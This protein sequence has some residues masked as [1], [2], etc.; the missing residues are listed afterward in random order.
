M[1]W[2]VGRYPWRAVIH[3]YLNH[4]ASST[5]R[6]GGYRRSPAAVRCETAIL[7]NRRSLVCFGTDKKL[8]SVK[9]DRY[10]E[11]ALNS[12]LLL[13]KRK[14]HEASWACYA[15]RPGMPEGPLPVIAQSHLER[16]W[17]GRCRCGV[18]LSGIAVA[19]VGTE[20]PDRDCRSDRHT[21]A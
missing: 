3:C 9:H 17:C 12:G 8:C 14:A 16:G 11:Q 10:V 1:W 6:Y 20:S 5:Y 18:A 7:R 19:G 4:C 21:V 2:F 13:F 15:A